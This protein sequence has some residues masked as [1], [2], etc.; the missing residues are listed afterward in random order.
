MIIFIDSDFKCHVQNDGTTQEVETD[1][2]DGKCQEFIEGYRFVPD[3][4][5][6]VREDGVEFHGEMIAS[7]KDYNELAQAQAAWEHEQFAEMQTA[8]GILGVKA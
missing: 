6:W 8:L 5:V 2:F 7:W 3:G 4:A 1:F